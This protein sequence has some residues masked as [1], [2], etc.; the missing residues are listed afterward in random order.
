MTAPGSGSLFR[1]DGRVALVTGSTRGLG[2]QIALHLARAGAR[3]AMNYANDR[4]AAEAAYDELCS[5]A[6][7]AWLARGDVTDPRSVESMCAEIRERLGPIDVLVLN[8]TCPQPQRAFE[9]YDWA[10]FVRMHDFFVKSPVLLMRACLSHMK[11]QAWGRIIHVTSEVF[12]LGTPQY[13]AY[14]AAK[15]GQTGLA[16]STARE[17]APYGITV[18]MVAPGWIPVERHA[19]EPQEKRDAYL[20][21]VPASRWGTPSDVAAATVYLASDEA[22]FVTGQTLAVNGGHT[23]Y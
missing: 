3:V 12:A 6:P 10:F 5:V 11:E 2:K 14:V 15:G 1:L 7:H 4:A 23:V 18:N 22:G 13:S 8:A 9:Q 17:L 20:A 21:E 19:D 16:R